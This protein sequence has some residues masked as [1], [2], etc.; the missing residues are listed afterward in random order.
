MNVILPLII[1]FFWGLGFVLLWRIPTL[2]TMHGYTV[3][4]APLSVIIPARNEAENLASLLQSIAAQA[5]RPKEVIVVNDQSQ[6]DTVRVAETAGCRVIHATN[7]PEGWIGKPWACYTG[8]RKAA[9]EILM[10]MDAD[11][12]LEPDGLKRILAT[13][14]DTRG[15]LSIQPYHR[16]E[17]AY[18]RLSAVFNI[19]VMAGM[20]TFTP[21]GPRLKPSGA[22]GPC[23]ICT[24]K[25]YFRIGG[26]QHA[27]GDVLES[28]ALGRRFLQSGLNVR[29]YG[30]KGSVWFQMYPHGKGFGT[31]AIAISPV[32]MIM[33]VC[34]VFG[35]V[36]L[37]RHLVESFITGASVVELVVWGGLDVLYILQNDWILRR[38]GNF[39][40][41][42]AFLFQI[43]LLFFVLVFFYSL[44]RVFVL[45][46]VRWKGRTLDTNKKR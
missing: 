26:H 30:G 37:T 14:E 12:R 15:L 41:R 1:L 24:K 36:S 44:V 10:F 20:N 32:L 16:M 17:K 19:I 27:R 43:P 8:A 11:T 38:I 5:L 40:F 46:R 35:G 34:W 2:K 22:F 7:P 31:G 45:G 33:L 6:D 3:T 9:G 39:G 28:L 29:C 42:T 21:L 4:S 18:E 25:D 23:N 13:F